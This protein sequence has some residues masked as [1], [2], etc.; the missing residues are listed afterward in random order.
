MI[1]V[2]LFTRGQ[3]TSQADAVLAVLHLPAATRS[4]APPP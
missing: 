3:L 1:L 2:S 4:A